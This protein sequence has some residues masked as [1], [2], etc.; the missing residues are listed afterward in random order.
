[1]RE[2]TLTV[3][4]F[5]R[6]CASALARIGVRRDAA[7]LPSDLGMPAHVLWARAFQ[8]GLFD[9][10]L[11]GITY[12]TAVGG[13]GLGVEY[14]EAF[15]RAARDYFFSHVFNVTLAIVG[16]TI[17]EWGTLE[18]QAGYVP[19]MLTGDDLWVQC[20]SEPSGGSDLA[21]ART[22]AKRD[23]DLYR[24]NGSKMWT[25]NAEH[26]QYALVLART[27]WDLP[28]HR[29]LSMFVVPMDAAGV[30]VAPIRHVDGTQEVCQEFFDD[31]E[32]PVSALVGDEHE[33]WSVARR[34]LLHERNMVS[35]SG[36]DGGT[37]EKVLW[38]PTV[39]DLL[40]LVRER[41]LDRSDHAAELL[42]EA[43]ASQRASDALRRWLP[44]QVAKGALPESAAAIGK[45]WSSVS[46]FRRSEMAVE[47]SGLSGVVWDGDDTA[48]RLAHMWPGARSV[49]IGGGTNEVMRN[50][51]AE[52]VLGLPKDPYDDST[53]PFRETAR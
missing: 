32:V 29:G 45:L 50:Q 44:A 36:S 37:V 49:T 4:S 28:K 17:L 26:A 38:S 22:S 11:A 13:R 1:M 24:L 47:L 52:R 14:Q 21:G 40:A 53:R 7:Q 48:I 12:P 35:G 27:D 6:E 3:E 16:P 46:K 18:Q 8:R 9:A 15:N 43:I 23:G 2:S 20:L 42:A 31:V 25:T 34:V 10:G 51:I 41:Q 19:R 39:E 5:E 33:G 30:T